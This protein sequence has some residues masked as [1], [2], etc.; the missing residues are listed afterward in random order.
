VCVGRR[1]GRVGPSGAGGGGTG[2]EEL[3]QRGHCSGWMG[4]GGLL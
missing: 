2:G 1:G 4:L 3:D